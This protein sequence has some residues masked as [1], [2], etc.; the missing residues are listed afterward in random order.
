MSRVVTVNERK[1]RE[2]ARRLAAADVVMAKLRAFG[3][4]R[5]GTFL[6]FGSAAEGRMKFDSDL[7]VVVDFP[8]EREAEAVDFVEDTCRK[9]NIPADI[10]VKSGAS[11]RFLDRIRN[12]MIQLP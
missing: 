2:R 5:G 7:D 9:Q 3:A 4:E 6:I 8:A 12:H 1:D 11:S 10:H